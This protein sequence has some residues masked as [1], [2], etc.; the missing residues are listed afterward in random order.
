LEEQA[1]IQNI[2]VVAAYYSRVT[3]ARLTELLDLPPLTTERTLCKLVTDKTI[4]ARIDRPR[5]VV[6]FKPQTNSTDILNSWTADIDKMLGLVEKTSHLV[7][8][9][10]CFFLVFGE[11]QLTEQEYAMHEA[12][13]GKKVKA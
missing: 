11:C 8:K 13:K 2:R 5:G 10:S 12:I 3:L 9:V 7:S 6:T 4:Y 1:D